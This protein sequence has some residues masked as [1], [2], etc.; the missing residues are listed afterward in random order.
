MKTR[1][2]RDVSGNPLTRFLSDTAMNV[3]S[4][5]IKVASSRALMYEVYDW[6]KEFDSTKFYGDIDDLQEISA[7]LDEAYDNYFTKSLDGSAK[8]SDGSL[9][10][11]F[12]TYFDRKGVGIKITNVRIYSYIFCKERSIDFSST[13]EALAEVKKW[14]AK[15]MALDYAK[16]KEYDDRYTYLMSTW[17]LENPDRDVLEGEEF[18]A[19]QLESEGLRWDFYND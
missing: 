11:S 10:V 12:G 15:E 14:H 1:A 3:A 9:T 16:M 4:S 13:E 7:L 8:G 18:V 17:I 5:L 19:Q 2:V 6:D